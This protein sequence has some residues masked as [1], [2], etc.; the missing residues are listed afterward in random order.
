MFNVIVLLNMSHHS[1][2]GPAVLDYP[3]TITLTSRQKLRT[4]N[5][6]PD[7]ILSENY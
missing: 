3:S 5:N 2:T 6:L 4:R 7:K 1:K